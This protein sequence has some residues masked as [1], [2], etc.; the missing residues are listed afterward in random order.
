MAVLHR[1]A[2][3]ASNSLRST[4]WIPGLLP[5]DGLMGERCR[6]FIARVQGRLPAGGH[7]HPR[8][9][10]QLLESL[11]QHIGASHRS[12]DVQRAC[13]LRTDPERK[14][15]FKKLAPVCCAATTP[16]ILRLS[17]NQDREQWH[18]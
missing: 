12:A 10:A 3:R 1:T 6:V 15:T 2:L 5:L 17:V 18:C 4:G 11:E 16:D 8:G 9:R 7:F 14:Q 13:F